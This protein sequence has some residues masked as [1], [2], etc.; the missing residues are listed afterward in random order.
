MT[1]DWIGSALAIL[2]M[3]ASAY[4]SRILGFLA[5]GRVPHH[6][7]VRRFLASLPGAI[8]VAI[9]VPVAVRAGAA[10]MLAI[11]AAL[12]VSLVTRNEFAAVAAGMGI[13]A[14][15]RLTGL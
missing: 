2:A 10:G 15:A 9:V 8:I 3:A 12:V 5:M 14:L 1:P 4:L 7:R 13:A 6:P 11:G